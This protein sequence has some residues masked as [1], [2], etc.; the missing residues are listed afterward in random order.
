VYHPNYVYPPPD[1]LH[2]L[3]DLY[4][5]YINTHLPLLHRP[6]FE[7]AVAEGL[8]LRAQNHETDGDDE[9]MFS[10]VLL[11]VCAVASR[12]SNDERVL[13]NP[14]Q[15]TGEDKSGKKDWHSSGWKYFNQVQAMRKSILASPT[16][17]DLQFYAVCSRFFVTLLLN[18]SIF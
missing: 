6:T 3:I 10:A 15:D 18:D 7:R 11:L 5:R 13:F 12:Y 1:L 14:T 4:F 2:S 9:T 17:H 16:L 8:H